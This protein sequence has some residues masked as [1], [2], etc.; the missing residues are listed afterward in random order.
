M[1]RMKWFWRCWATASF[2]M[3]AAPEMIW[4]VHDKHR[5]C[6]VATRHTTR[7]TECVYLSKIGR[8]GQNPVLE[9]LFVGLEHAVDALHLGL[10]KMI[11]TIKILI[12]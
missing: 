4:P 9:R 8:T 3:S 5:T 1:S 6:A 7:H 10:T 2:A 11:I 12:M